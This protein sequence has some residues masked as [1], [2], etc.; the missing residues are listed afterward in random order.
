MRFY[1]FTL[2]LLSALLA[3]AAPLASD[4]GV[5]RVNTVLSR[6]PLSS[7]SHNAVVGKE[8]SLAVEI[9][10]AGETFVDGLEDYLKTLPKRSDNPLSMRKRGDAEEL[11]L[12]GKRSEDMKVSFLMAF[13]TM[14]IA[15]VFTFSNTNDNVP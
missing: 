1:E 7:F 11:S 15:V 14:H 6:R 10:D 8:S 3:A 13:S 9:R 12:E 4:L 5:S 2:L